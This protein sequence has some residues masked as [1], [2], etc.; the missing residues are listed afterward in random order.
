MLAETNSVDVVFVFI[1][2][3]GRAIGGRFVES[4]NH[5]LGQVVNRIANVR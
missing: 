1:E 3:A 4:I 5:L 2:M